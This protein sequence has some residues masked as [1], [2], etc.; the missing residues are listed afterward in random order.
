MNPRAALWLTVTTTI[1]AVV[2]GILFYLA[3]V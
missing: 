1:P 2:I 3:G